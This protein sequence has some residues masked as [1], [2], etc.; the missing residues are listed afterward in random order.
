[1]RTITRASGSFAAAR[2]Q[3]PARTSPARTSAQSAARSGARPAPAPGWKGWLADPDHRYSAI[4]W[5]L[6][7]ALVVYTLLVVRSTTARNVDFNELAAAMS[8]APGVSE[9]EAIDA[10]GFQDRLG[11]APEDCEGWLLYGSGDIMNVSELMVVKAT[12][13][14]ARERFESACA[15]RVEAQLNIFRSYGVDQK[16]LLEDAILWQRGSYVFYG[17]SENADAWEEL[18][19]SRIR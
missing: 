10:N 9:L 1:M 7:A 16:D 6:L 8:A 18:F 11:I 2:A 12:D 4:R 3:A 19:L 14:D 17:V 13:E 5:A 15:A